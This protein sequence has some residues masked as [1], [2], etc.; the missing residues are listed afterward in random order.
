MG[1]DINELKNEINKL[2]KEVTQLKRVENQQERLLNTHQIL[3]DN[4]FQDF[5]IK[6]KGVLNYTHTL[7][8]EVLNFVDNVCKKYDLEW[9]IDYGNYLG[10]VRHGDFIPWDDDLDIGMMRKDCLKFRDIIRDEIKLHGLD[11]IFKVSHQRAIREDYLAAFTQVTV[12][13]KGGLYAGIDIFAN[14]YS[15]NPV[16]KDTFLK[17]KADLHYYLVKGMSK[18]EA[19]DKLYAD[20]DFSYEKQAYYIP[21]MEGGW[22]KSVPFKLFEADKVFPLKEIKFGERSYPC[23]KE[24]NYYLSL[25]YG[26][27]FM[28]IPRHIIRHQRV[29][30]L[31][32]KENVERN[33]EI[34]IKRFREANENFLY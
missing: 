11:D 20:Y 14:D 19:I 23:P 13:Y 2:K 29:I 15:K 24:P 27:N 26:E 10:A 5:D 17:A 9:W 31:K 16:D 12:V 18:K 3:L 30:R 4:L 21:C 7:C 8:K 34:F 1:E 22:G 33:F 6:P 25:R 32:Q 28:E